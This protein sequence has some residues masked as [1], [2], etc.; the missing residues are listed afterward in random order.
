VNE[1]DW[2]AV[3]EGLIG[4]V[5]GFLVGAVWVLSR[6]LDGRTARRRRDNGGERP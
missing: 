4:V 5:L 3:G 1:A 2:L 6:A